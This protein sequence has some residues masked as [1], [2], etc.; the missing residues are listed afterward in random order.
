MTKSRHVFGKAIGVTLVVSG[1][2][3]DA[4]YIEGSSE[5]ME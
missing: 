3:Y 2:M 1:K 5:E 4:H